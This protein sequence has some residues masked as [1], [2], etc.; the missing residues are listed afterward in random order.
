MT[1]AF[2]CARADA[3]RNN[4]QTGFARLNRITEEPRGLFLNSHLVNLVN[5]VNLRVRVGLWIFF[6]NAENDPR[7]HITKVPDLASG[8]ELRYNPPPVDRKEMI[9]TRVL[10]FT[11]LLVSISAATLTPSTFSERNLNSSIYYP[12][13]GAAWQRRKPEDA[14]MDSAALAAAVAFAE[15]QGGSMPKDFSTQV[16]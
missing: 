9:K 5:P 2:I 14:G 6:R 15:T 12:A 10:A 11:V 7:N 16:E 8:G 1:C 4:H 3:R 13:A